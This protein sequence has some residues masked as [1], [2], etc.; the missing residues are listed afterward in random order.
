MTEEMPLLHEK[1]GELNIH[2]RHLDE[3]RFFL[4]EAAATHE[5]P[6]GN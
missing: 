4:K 1:E 2:N 3:Q 6:M 5:H